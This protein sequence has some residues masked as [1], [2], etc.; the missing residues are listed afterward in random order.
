M[1]MKNLG[2]APISQ[3]NGIFQFPEKPVDPNAQKGMGMG[4]GFPPS[5][6]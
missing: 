2:F 6:R 3:K 4:G 1:K 5:F